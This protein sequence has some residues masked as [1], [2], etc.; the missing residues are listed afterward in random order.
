[1]QVMF[2]VE[3][4]FLIDRGET[5]KGFTGGVF[6]VRSNRIDFSKMRRIYI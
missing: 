4:L 6:A 3:Y 5:I 2:A 1:M